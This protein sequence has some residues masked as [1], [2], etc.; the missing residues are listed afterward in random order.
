[1]KEGCKTSAD[2]A[3]RNGEYY[4]VGHILITSSGIMWEYDNKFSHT[5]DLRYFSHWTPLPELPEE[6]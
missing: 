5:M 6:D 1:M 2:V 4:S 3:L